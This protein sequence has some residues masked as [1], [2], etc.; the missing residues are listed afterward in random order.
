MGVL[1]WH[2]DW[3]IFLHVGAIRFS[4]MFAVAPDSSNPRL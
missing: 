3:C 1:N 2:V 4:E